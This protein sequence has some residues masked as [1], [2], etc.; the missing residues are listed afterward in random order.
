MR[1]SVTTKQRDFTEFSLPP[2]AAIITWEYHTFSQWYFKLQSKVCPATNVTTISNIS[3]DEFTWSVA[4]FTK[5]QLLYVLSKHGH[6]CQW[7]LN[8]CKHI[9]LKIFL[10]L[11][12]HI[13]L[14]IF[15][16]SPYF[17]I[18][19]K[20]SKNFLSSCL[21]AAMWDVYVQLIVP[22]SQ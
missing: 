9:I 15:E 20:F 3:D 2:L 4:E 7:H 21:Y 17:V 6:A 10:L 22:I 11:F 18:N 8:G 16:F 12:C 19:I 5:L 14:F 1:K 13:F